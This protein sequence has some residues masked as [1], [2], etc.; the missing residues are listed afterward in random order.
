[1]INDLISILEHTE[2]SLNNMLKAFYHMAQYEGKYLY[3]RIIQST[4]YANTN[5]VQSF[6][7]LLAPYLKSPDCSLLKALVKA[8]K[9]EEALERLTE[10][11]D[12]SA[13]VKLVN[14]P[15]S[16]V[17]ES[18]SLEHP[19]VTGSEALG[20]A[21]SSPPIVRSE[22][23]VNH[24]P[25][26]VTATVAADEIS[27]GILRGIHSLICGVFR[28]VP[29][30]HQFDSVGSCSIT[31][32]WATSKKIASQMQSVVLDD[33]DLKLLLRENIVSIQVGMEYSVSTGIMEYWEVSTQP[34][35]N[36]NI[37]F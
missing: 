8:A 15:K 29:S 28:T 22:P 24:S 17:P 37:F 34:E 20:F 31:V 27:W 5:S 2:D 3:I 23:T 10:Y 11:L 26:P 19:L 6:F 35:H 25:V 32:T 12:I 33:G 7:Q 14:F 13:N 21:A 16:L 4:E 18:S 9:C 36:V 30:S 1:M